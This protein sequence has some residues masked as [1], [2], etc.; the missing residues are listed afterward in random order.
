MSHH[1]KMVVFLSLGLLTVFAWHFATVLG[2]FGNAPQTPNEFFIRLGIILIGFILAS[3]ITSILVIRRHNEAASLPDERETIIELKSDRVGVLTLYLGLLVLL[4]FI[5]TP[6]TPMQIAN[7]ILAVVC[8]SET[9]KIAY[10]L[11]ILKRGI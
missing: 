3:V 4:W 10:A 2:F 8:F 1:V 5:F 9:I 7:G 11:Y 6:M